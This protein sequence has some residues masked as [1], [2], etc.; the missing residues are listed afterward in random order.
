MVCDHVHVEG[1]TQLRPQQDGVTQLLRGFHAKRA[2]GTGA[3]IETRVDKVYRCFYV[4]ED[5]AS[6][7]L[8]RRVFASMNIPITVERGGGGMDANRLNEHGVECIGLATGYAQ[9]HTPNEYVVVDDLI[10]SGEMVK[11]IILQYE[12]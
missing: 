4:S 8:M 12:D 6:I 10:K 7:S 3:T 2:E 9:N 1:E 11:Q 5:S